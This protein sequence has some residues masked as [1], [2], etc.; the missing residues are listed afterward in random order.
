[1]T[2][3]QIRIFME[4]S[5]NLSFSKTAVVFNTTQPTI[6]RQIQLLEEDWGITL[7]DRGG[8][9]VKLTKSGKVMADFFGAQYGS[10]Q[11]ALDQAKQCE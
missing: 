7:F 1:M 2:E 5:R 9:V 8:K 4:L 3:K 6:T 11:R 10:L